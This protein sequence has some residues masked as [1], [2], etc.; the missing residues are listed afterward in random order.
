LLEGVVAGVWRREKRGI[1]FD[2]FA[3]PPRRVRERIEAEA[4]ALGAW[5]G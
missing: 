1:A 3:E 4:A 2:L 5:A